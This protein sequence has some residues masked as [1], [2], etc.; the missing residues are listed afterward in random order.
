MSDKDFRLIKLD[1]E[2]YVI[3]KWQFK[4][5]LEA[6]NLSNVFNRPGQE[7]VA[8]EIEKKQALALLRSSLSD[9]NMLKI[10]NCRTFSEAWKALQVCF[11]NKTAY[12]PQALYQR[13]NTFKIASASEVSAG[14]SEIRGIQV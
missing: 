13:L 11:E 1:K 10:I 6:K 9:D 14:I 3:W 5:V 2:N 7:P 12:E 4:N 8:T